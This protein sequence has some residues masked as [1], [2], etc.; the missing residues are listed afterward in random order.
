MFCIGIYAN[1]LFIREGCWFGGGTVVTTINSRVS[2]STSV[3]FNC[4]EVPMLVV[5]RRCSL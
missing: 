4:S 3:S 2:D 5:V 1:K